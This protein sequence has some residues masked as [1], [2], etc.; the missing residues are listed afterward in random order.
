MAFKKVILAAGMCFTGLF[1][2][3]EVTFVEKINWV[4]NENKGGGGQ[5][6]TDS[7]RVTKTEE[8]S[9]SRWTAL[10]QYTTQK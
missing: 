7:L 3:K 8:K 6:R 1:H 5:V 4:G 2:G 9:Y 10:R